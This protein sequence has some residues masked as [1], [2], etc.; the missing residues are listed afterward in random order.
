MK[1]CDVAWPQATHNVIETG[2]P[3]GTTVT[4]DEK[5]NPQTVP[6]NRKTRRQTAWAMS[7]RL[8]RLV[9][10][11]E[12]HERIRRVTKAKLS[13]KRR[14]GRLAR[15]RKRTAYFARAAEIHAARPVIG[16]RIPT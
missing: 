10:Q 2:S 12:R 13:G 16:E 4:R 1:M 8:E 3:F 9:E 14:R 6:L 11:E 5:G 15:A 7:T